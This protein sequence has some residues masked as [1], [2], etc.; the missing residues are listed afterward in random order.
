ML[1]RQSFEEARR[2]AAAP[3]A[4]LTTPNVSVDEG[5]TPP[6]IVRFRRQGTTGDYYQA[7]GAAAQVRLRLLATLHARG[8]LNGCVSRESARRRLAAQQSQAWQQLQWVVNEMRRLDETG[9]S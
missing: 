7:L 5:L 4:Q 6:E 3:S 9:L 2:M 8:A 1:T